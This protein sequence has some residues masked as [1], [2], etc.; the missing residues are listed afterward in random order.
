MRKV[1]VIDEAMDKLLTTVF[2]FAFKAAGVQVTPAWEQL[3]AA[4]K[5]EED[6]ELPEEK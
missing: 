5:F 1:L 3:K 6:P 2:D 4:I